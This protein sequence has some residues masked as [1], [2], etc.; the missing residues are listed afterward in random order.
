MAINGT[1]LLQAGVVGLNAIW[2]SFATPGAT[3]N[4]KWATAQ[5]ITHYFIWSQGSFL[6]EKVVSFIIIWGVRS[7]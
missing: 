5:T 6:K 2:A 3:L 7:L 4:K 1:I